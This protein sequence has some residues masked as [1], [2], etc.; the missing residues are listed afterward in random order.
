MP[1]TQPLDQFVKQQLQSGIYPDYETMVEA[2]LKV[3]QEREEASQRI[4]DE[5][6]P[7]YERFKG[8]EPGISLDAEDIIRR[9][10]ERHAAKH[11]AS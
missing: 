5:L 10:R 4:A 3:L 11:S 1:N 9:G 6:R 7:A 8:G 2:G